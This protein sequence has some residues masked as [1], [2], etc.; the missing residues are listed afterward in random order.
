MKSDSRG[1]TLR[2]A[3]ER[4]EVRLLRLDMGQHPDYPIKWC[5]F[6]AGSA[7]GTKLIDLLTLLYERIESYAIFF[8]P[9]FCGRMSISQIPLWLV[10]SH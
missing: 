1:I 8:S 10:V 2:T 5:S 6:T 4:S 7:E 9:L 3:A